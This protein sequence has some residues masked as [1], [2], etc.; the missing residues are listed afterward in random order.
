M[1]ANDYAEQVVN[2]FIDGITDQI[3]LSIEHDDKLRL[4]YNENVR[5]Y[6]E[7][8]VNQS[9][10]KKVKELLNLKNLDEC[11]EPKSRLIT[12]YTRHKV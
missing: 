7:D 3:F 9:I 12:S 10:G 1:S 2:R 4:E 5:L 11:K 6:T 8:T